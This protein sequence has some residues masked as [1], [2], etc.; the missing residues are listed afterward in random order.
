EQ[1]YRQ[2]IEIDEAII[3]TSHPDYAIDLNNLA[4]LLKTTGRY[5]E[6]EQLYRQAIEVFEDTLGAEH[7]N[8]QT[9]KANLQRMLDEKS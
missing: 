1:L 6:A 4:Y 7:P 2:A 5:D 3:G 9:G 8:T